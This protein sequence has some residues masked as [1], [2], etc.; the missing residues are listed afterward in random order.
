MHQ[1]VEQGY[2]QMQ[3][4]GFAVPQQQGQQNY[5]QSTFSHITQQAS[6]QYNL[7][8]VAGTGRGGV[9]TQMTSSMNSNQYQQTFSTAAGGGG[10]T[11]QNALNF[12]S[13]LELAEAFDDTD[14]TI[15]EYLN[16]V[17]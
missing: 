6:S 9:P 15:E 14:M 2:D 3:N 16:M 1:Q 7:S 8:A 12:M 17:T 4:Q 10:V 13:A 11:A 5:N